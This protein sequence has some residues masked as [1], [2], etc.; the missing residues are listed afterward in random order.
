MAI[1]KGN[2][3]NNTLNGG[4]GDDA[5]YGYAGDDILIGGAGNDLLNGGGG[6]DILIGGT[7]NDTLNGGNGIDIMMGGNGDDMY[8]VNDGA[9]VTTELAAAGYDTVSSSSDYTLAANFEKLILTGAAAINGTGNALD[10]SLRGNNADNV[11]DGGDG[12]D[13]LSGGLGVDTLWGGAGNDSLKIN[14]FNGDHIDGG[15]GFDTMQIAADN[16]ILNLSGTPSI[17]NIE[18]IRLGDSHSTLMVSPQSILDLS[19]DSDTLKVDATGNSNTLQIDGGW[20][21]QGAVHGYHTFTQY[22][23]TLQV[24][25]LITDIVVFAPTAYTISDTSSAANVGSVFDIGVQEITIDF[26]GQAYSDSG[27]ASIDLT[28]FGLE[29]KLIVAQHDGVL[30]FGTAHYHISNT[31]YYIHETASSKSDRVSWQA[32]AT[33]A[34]IVSAHSVVVSI[35]S[36]GSPYYSRQTLGSIQVTGI[37]AGLSDSQFVFV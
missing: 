7:G 2:N 1:L 34:K 5:L 29:D 18:A 31:R 20:T 19:S 28:G 25:P 33:A 26:G 30:N 15:T 9:D 3:Q 27:V 17:T 36:Y 12:N 35:N 21:D 24:N 22:G 8:F 23:A 16:Q 37:P 32:G 14:D 10:N 4:S 13:A 11:L 6:A